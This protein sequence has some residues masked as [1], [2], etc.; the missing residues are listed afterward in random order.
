MRV[1]EREAPDLARP[2]KNVNGGAFPQKGGRGC[3]WRESRNGRCSATTPKHESA[4]AHYTDIILQ[5]KVN[6][7]LFAE[8][9]TPVPIVVV[10]MVV[11]VAVVVV[12]VVALMPFFYHNSIVN[13]GTP[14][15][16]GLQTLR[17][18]GHAPNDL[19]DGTRFGRRGQDGT[20]FPQ[21]PFDTLV[22]CLATQTASHCLCR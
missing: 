18:T 3:E 22:R 11:V 13:T 17:S 21:H 19:T 5:L 14:R 10:V 12:V 7:A 6:T 4:R 15:N 8:H 9:L 2:T 20:K 16:G 1:F